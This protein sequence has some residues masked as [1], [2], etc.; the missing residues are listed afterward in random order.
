MNEVLAIGPSEVRLPSAAHITLTQRRSE[1]G[2]EYWAHYEGVAQELPTLLRRHGLPLTLRWLH[3][4]LQAN[5]ERGRAQRELLRD[6]IA[7]A[8][9][10]NFSPEHLQGFF[11]PEATGRF[12]LE[13]RTRAFVAHR[14]L[15]AA[16]AMC[17]VVKL[18]EQS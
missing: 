16:E 6:W 9:V 13:M 10:P 2:A 7:M 11:V 4:E 3:D 5:T 8:G 1:N 17:I 15:D 14:M 18:T 12:P